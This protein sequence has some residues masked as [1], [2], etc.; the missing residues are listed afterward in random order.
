MISDW[1]LLI[2]Q[3][4]QLKEDIVLALNKLIKDGKISVVSF[5]TE[6]DVRKKIQEVALSVAS[7]SGY[8]MEYCY[9]IDCVCSVNLTP[10]MLQIDLENVFLHE[11][12]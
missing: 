6:D 2:E 5:K 10:T 11:K 7:N 9:E 8:D 1:L 4:K 12:I 3:E